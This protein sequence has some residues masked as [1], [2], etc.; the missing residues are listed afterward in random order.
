MREQA[1]H[2]AGKRMISL[3]E[4]SGTGRKMGVL[5][6]GAAILFFGVILAIHGW[7]YYFLD[8][9]ARP[10]SPK[11]FDL[12]PS[13]RIGIRLGM[14]GFVLLAM[15]YLYPLRK[16]WMYLGR[17]G[18]TRN[19]FNYHVLLGLTAP[20]LIT[21]HSAF[22][23]HGFAGIAYW[24]MIA[25]VISGVI[26][27]YFYAQIPRNI[28][29]AEMSLKEME[30]LKADLIEQLKNQ[31]ALPPAEIEKMFH[32]PAGREIQSMSLYRVLMQMILLDIARP[33]K[34]W[35][36]RRRGIKASGR[37]AWFAG[38]V[39]TGDLELEK[40]IRLASRQA[41]LSKRI[42]FLSQTQ[43]VFHGWHVVHRPFSISFAIFVLIHVSVVAWFGYF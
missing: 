4:Q 41:A 37:S 9:A 20:V 33:F 34:A 31:K 26:G 32:L 22:K 7:D 27:R 17:F 29:A 2:A 23:L 28:G 43:R 6:F 11:H 38:V 24:T 35:S 8:L 5:L 21:F 16:H 12:K 1:I 15:V 18:K 42:L 3:V 30:E 14:S 36:M 10:F 19:W 25:L 13:G 40:A 39:R